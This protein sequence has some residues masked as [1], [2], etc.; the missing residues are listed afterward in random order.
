MVQ[1]SEI[2]IDDGNED[3]LT[4][5]GVSLTEVHQV[6]ANDPDIRRN[7]RTEQELTWRSVEPA[8]VEVDASSFR[9]SIEAAGEF[10]PSVR[11]R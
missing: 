11:G 6:L 5:H 10:G 8:V 1:I 4:G 7:V 3:H 2:E 9:S